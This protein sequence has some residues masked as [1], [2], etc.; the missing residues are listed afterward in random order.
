MSPLLSRLKKT[1]FFL[2][3][4][5]IFTASI[6]TAQTQTSAP[7]EMGTVPQAFKIAGT[8]V[9]AVTG[10]PL[11]RA[12]VS[13][14]DTRARMQRVEIVTGED[15]HFEFSPLP[16]AKYALQGRKRGYIS[17]GYDQHEQY[18][19]AI[20]T[21]PEFATDNLVFRLMPMAVI[22]GHV[23]DESGEPV[24]GARI[25]LFDENHSGGMNRVSRMNSAIAD[26]RGYFEFSLLPPGSYFVSANATPWYAVYPNARPGIEPTQKIPPDL[27]VAYPT[28]YYGGATDSEGATPLALK[29]GEHKEIDIRLVAVPALRLVFHVPVEQPAEGQ[30]MQPRGYF[31]NIVLQ[32][33]VFD[34][35]E[36]TREQT[37]MVEPGVFEVTGVAAGRYDVAINSNPGTPGMQQLGEMNLTRD[38]QD[39]GSTESQPSAT[40]KVQLKT[41]EDE[42]LPK[43]YFLGLRD[44]RQRVVAGQRGD[45]SGGVTLEAVHP[46]KYGIVVFQMGQG[47]RYSVIHLSSGNTALPGREV[48][49]QPG[50]NLELTAELATG[51]ERID[52]V[53]QKNGKPLA[54][55]MVALVPNNPESN[56][57]LFRRDQ[58]DFDGTFSLQGV[59]PGNYTVV[60]VEDAWGFEWLKAGVLAR[61]VQHGQQV[62]IGEKMRGT[63]H[64]PEPVEV[65]SK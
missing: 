35:L 9:N 19:T 65:Q 12:H 7:Q 59:I 2:A 50:E 17:A 15:G 6:A 52:G 23:L 40:L 16:A 62:I 31:A 36:F 41:S 14:A 25:G 55:V 45:A 13:L 18:S 10:A 56:V 44:S 46:G 64:L 39:L 54:G 47:K 48:D 38:G 27:N 22:S 20:V 29:G 8:V 1:G 34:F 4:S 61:Y 30:P 24:R 33:H 28:T 5:A 57:D 11:A 26:D 51:Q 63:L 49:L 60:A 3:L 43:Q 32:K 53:V 42:P 21:G 37:Q 58:S